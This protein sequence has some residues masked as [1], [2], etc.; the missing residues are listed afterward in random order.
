MVAFV[1]LAAGLSFS[2]RGDAISSRMPLPF[3]VEF[4]EPGW[5][6]R[7]VWRL[8]EVVRSLT[9]QLNSTVGCEEI[10]VGTGP[11]GGVY[12]IRSHAPNVILPIAVG[13][14]DFMNN[15]TCDVSFLALH[16]L[17]HDGVSELLAETSQ[18][19]PLG[20]PRLY[21]W[22]QNPYP[23]LQAFARVNIASSWSHGLGFLRNVGGANDRF[24]STFCGHGEI[25]EFELTH[26]TASNGFSTDT[27]GWRKVG[28]LPASGE[29]I[30]VADVDGDDH[31]DLCLATGFA[32]QKAAVHIYSKAEYGLD[33]GPSHVIDEGRRFGNVK[34]LMTNPS[35][36]PTEI[37]AWW[38]T[39]D[40]DGD[41]E[42]VRYHWS[43]TGEFARQLIAA[44]P[45]SELW[46]MD[47]QMTLAD[48]NDDGLDEVWFVT[49]SGYVLRIDL[50]SP[51]PLT[52]VCRV[53]SE[54]GPLTASPKCTGQRAGLYIGSKELVLRL[55]PADSE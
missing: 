44:G 4:H 21:V 24:V 10:F 53:A 55:E 23:Q 54:L 29:G 40:F 14:G 1:A 36:G 50:E 35:S 15:G 18:I 52:R 49:N 6:L 8:P 7:F 19:Y 12:R 46:P 39:G 3:A 42:L 9:T 32:E 5:Q 37:I 2:P 28:Q 17:D 45:A 13:L 30:A 51:S 16:D 38:C 25:V 27:I 41:S 48:T 26:A 47:C 20:C 43:S 33:A 11:R 22:S 34:I 31:P